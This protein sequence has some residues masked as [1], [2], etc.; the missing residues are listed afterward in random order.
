MPKKVQE[1]EQTPGTDEGDNHQR[2]SVQEQ[3]NALGD[4]LHE[5]PSPYPIILLTEPRNLPV[6]LNDKEINIKCKELSKVVR[7]LNEEEQSQED[8]KKQM[9]ARLSGLNDQMQ[10]LAHIVDKG[11]EYRVVDVVI[12][13]HENDIVQEIRQDTGD[14]MISRPARDTERQLALTQLNAGKA[15]IRD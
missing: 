11:E 2:G 12:R 1:T 7:E 5:T 10:R 8:E 9:K 4:K 3:I 14:I 15:E 13:A 6:K